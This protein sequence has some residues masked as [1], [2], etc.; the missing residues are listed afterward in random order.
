VAHALRRAV[1]ALMRIP[2]I[3]R[4]QEWGRGTHEWVRN[5][6]YWQACIAR[7]PAAPTVL[8]KLIVAELIVLFDPI[9][10]V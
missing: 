8:D 7:L 3:M 10:S 2:L 4:P 9:S 6:L 1:F 5:G